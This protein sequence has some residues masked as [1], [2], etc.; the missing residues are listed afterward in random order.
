M[1]ILKVYDSQNYTDEMPVFEKYSVRG[2]IVRNGKIATQRGNDGDY[3]ILGGGVEAGE[4]FSDALLREVQEESG[5]RIRRETIREV[6]EMLEMR[7]DL[8]TKGMKYVCHSCFYLC[9]A[10]R[11]LGET[12]MTES[13]IAKGYH[14]V[15]ATPDEIIAGNQPF[16]DEPWI[17]RDTEFVEM[18]KE[19]IAHVCET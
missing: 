18:M 11:E 12:H 15:W 1:K 7:E 10:E 3:K 8:F 16:M 17:R 14:L 5:L 13:E 19:E 2:V 9:E 6:G 4:E